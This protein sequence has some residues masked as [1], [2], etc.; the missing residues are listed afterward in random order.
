[1]KKNFINMEYSVQCW[2]GGKEGLVPIKWTFGVDLV[3]ALV[4]VITGIS[5]EKRF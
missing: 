2:D 4:Q 1:M 5:G 3:F